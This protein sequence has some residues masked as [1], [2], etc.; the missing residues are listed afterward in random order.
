MCAIACETIEQIVAV[1]PDSQ[2]L[3]FEELQA[4]RNA[5]WLKQSPDERLVKMLEGERA[6]GQLGIDQIALGTLEGGAAGLSLAHP[7]SFTALWYGPERRCHGIVLDVLIAKVRNGE[8][9]REEAIDELIRTH[10]SGPS[11]ATTSYAGVFAR[12]QE[13]FRRSDEKASVVDAALAFLQFRSKHGRDAAALDE[14]V[15]EFLAAVPKDP[16]HA[17]PLKMRVDEAGRNEQEQLPAPVKTSYV[18]RPLVRIYSCG[19][20]GKD[21]GGLKIDSE[22]KDDAVF[23]VP[24]LAPLPKEIGK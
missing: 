1:Q 13:S 22:L 8:T 20:N 9:L 17:L 10:Q 14:L 19:Q 18:N 21:D 2:P 11:I 6:F 16:F 12:C 24:R 23:V 15:P 7:E 5:L 3:T 4:Y